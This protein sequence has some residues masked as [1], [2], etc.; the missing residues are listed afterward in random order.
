[1]APDQNRGEKIQSVIKKRTHELSEPDCKRIHE[2]FNGDGPLAELFSQTDITEIMVNGPF[3]IW[4]EKNGR[5]NRFHDRFV[6]KNSF[7][8][9]CFRLMEEAKVQLTSENPTAHGHLRQFRLHMIGCELTVSN[10]HLSF[11]R[12]PENPWTLQKL[13]EKGWG[14]QDQIVA[15]ERLVESKLNFLVVGGTGTGKTSVL[16]ACLQRLPENERT[17]LIEDTLE[18]KIPNTASMRLL[19]REDPNGILKKVDQTELVRNALRLRPDRLVM[20]EIRGDEAKD[21][22]MALATGHAGSFGT[23][24]AATAAQALIRLEML[25]QIGAPNWSLSAVRRLIQ[26][27]LQAIVVIGR[28]SE[29]QRYLEGVYRISSLEEN[30]ILLER[31]G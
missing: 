7:R 22:L 26:M 6:S 12:H 30:G 28:N 15:L 25:I 4:F 13:G 19:T 2:E 3:E 10:V 20:G 31:V 24:H 14:K 1:M 17:V 27:S 5:L 9:Y 29:G 18:L 23:L 11:R 16:N 21:F 8:N